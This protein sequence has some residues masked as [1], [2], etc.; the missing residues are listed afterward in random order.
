ME[1]ILLWEGSDENRNYTTLNKYTTHDAKGCVPAGDSLPGSKVTCMCHV[2]KDIWIGTEV[3]LSIS[4]VTMS[5]HWFKSFN[6]YISF[7]SFPGFKRTCGLFS[8]L[9]F[10]YYQCLC[11]L[12]PFSLK[13]LGQIKNIL[14]LV[15]WTSLKFVI[16]AW[17]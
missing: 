8:P 11:M 7:I 17:I 10:H 5:V 6:N 16:L 4:L 9:V 12:T 14:S 13:L 1:N 15:D 3:S 2:N